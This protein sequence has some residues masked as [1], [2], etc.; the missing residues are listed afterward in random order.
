MK[1]HLPKLLLSPLLA[2]TIFL[3]SAFTVLPKTDFELTVIA[4]KC[5]YVLR[6]PELDVYKG[7]IYLKGKDSV[8][9]RI[10]L[11]TLIP[12]VDATVTFTPNGNE[13]FTFTKECVGSEIDKIRLLKDIELACKH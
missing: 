2:T 1:K 5:K 4:G 13:L 11:D 7:Q 3:C 12:A 10:Y 6:Y 8:V 9:E